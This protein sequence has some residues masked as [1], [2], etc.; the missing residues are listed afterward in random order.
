M[1]LKTTLITFYC[2]VLGI[3]IIVIPTS[4]IKGRRALASNMPSIAFSRWERPETFY[5]IHPF[6]PRL[7]VHKIAINLGKTFSCEL[8]SIGL[9]RVMQSYARHNLSDGNC[10]P[11]IISKLDSF[12]GL[13]I[14]VIWL[15]PMYVFHMMMWDK[16]FL[17]TRRCIRSTVIWKI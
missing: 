14:D 12:K 9:C 15:S 5:F 16:I 17:I 4:E 1:N 8:T 7:S 6:L 10:T 13:G 11:A 3:F 2:A